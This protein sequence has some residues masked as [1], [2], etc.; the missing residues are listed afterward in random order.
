LAT[1]L[2]ELGQGLG[3]GS[4]SADAAGA[5]D[6]VGGEIPIIG[7]AG[8]DHSDIRGACLGRVQLRHNRRK[9]VREVGVGNR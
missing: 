1:E 2:D 6:A 3:Q 9:P 7:A 5:L 4:V 8:Q